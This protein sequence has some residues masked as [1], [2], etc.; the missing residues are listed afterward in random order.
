MGLDDPEAALSVCLLSLEDLHGLPAVQE[1]FKV[2]LKEGV[3][4]MFLKT[5]RLYCIM[6]ILLINHALYDFDCKYS[7]YP[8]P[9]SW[10]TIQLE[11]RIFCPI[12][13]THEILKSSSDDPDPNH[14]IYMNRVVIDKRIKHNR[15]FFTVNSRGDIILLSHDKITVIYRT[16]ESKDIILPH[17]EDTDLVEQKRQ[18]LAVDNNDDVYVVRWLKESEKL[19][20]IKEHFVLHV[21]DKNYKLKVAG[22]TF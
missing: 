3:R 7:K 17:T 9:F 11:D 20:G 16:G 10:P 22:N 13:N 8:H 4:S 18:D 2:F 12:I 14:H 21:F 19:K 6:S 15:N 5:E 1:I